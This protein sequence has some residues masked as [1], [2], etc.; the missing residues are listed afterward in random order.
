VTT[1]ALLVSG[2][3]SSTTQPS[4]SKSQKQSEETKS[5]PQ[6]VPGV[7]FVVAPNKLRVCDKPTV[8]KVSWDAMVTGGSVKI[9]VLDDKKETLFAFGGPKGSADTGPWVNAKTVFVLKDA[10]ETKQLAKFVVGSESCN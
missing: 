8:A 2:C 6:A 9:F 10:E 1:G 5:V 4:A 3:D 7:T